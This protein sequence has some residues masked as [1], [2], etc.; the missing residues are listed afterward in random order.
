MAK[1]KGQTTQWPREEGQTTQWPRE[2]GQTTQWPTT[3]IKGQTNND[4]QNSSSKTED[5]A[6]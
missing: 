6:N 4:Q 2:E 3:E 1:S 5:R